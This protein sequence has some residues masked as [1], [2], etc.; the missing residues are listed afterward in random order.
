LLWQANAIFCSGMRNPGELWLDLYA[1]AA[2]ARIQILAELP[3][4]EAVG[5]T[6]NSRY[7]ASEVALHTWIIVRS[8]ESRRSQVRTLA[9]WGILQAS[10]L[11]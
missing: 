9:R 5:S 7:A 6:S 4:L 8:P 11:R 2:P 3:D 1:A 10:S